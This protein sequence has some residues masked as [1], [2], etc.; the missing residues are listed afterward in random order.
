MPEG[1][2]AN[3]AVTLRPSVTGSSVRVQPWPGDPFWGPYVGAYG[4][5]Y[6]N[7]YGRRFGWYDPGWYPAGFGG[8][9][10]DVYRQ[11]LELDIDSRTQPGK[12]YYEGRAEIS[13]DGDSPTKSVPIL[14]RALFADFPGNN[15]QTRRIDVPVDPAAPSGKR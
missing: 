9:T 8:Y 14:I 3:L 1:S 4:G 12:R 2:Q 13:V 15:G 11:R 6:G 10:L 7:F 5:F